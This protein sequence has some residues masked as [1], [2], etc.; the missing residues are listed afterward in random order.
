MPR[1]KQFSEQEILQK[2]MELFWKQGYY[3][4]SIQN[5]VD[6][7]GINRASLYDTFGG[8]KELFDKAFQ[9]YRASN[10]QGFT[11]FLDAQSGVK[12]GLRAL[13]YKAIRET[14]EDRDRKG[15]FV[16]N[17]T[18]ELTPDDQEMHTVLQRN[19]KVFEDL[20]Y[21]FLL[22]GEASGEIPPGKDLSAIAGLLFTIYNGINIIGKIES[23]PD[24]LANSVEIA[25]NLL[26]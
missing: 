12:E 11:K 21:Q 25:L 24:R 17:A 16:V 19:K 26:N 18:I 22:K 20:F 15:C 1:T 6:H 23:D 5:L 4:T 7:L 14:V 9:Q 10:T 13:F 8:K 3:A 2:A